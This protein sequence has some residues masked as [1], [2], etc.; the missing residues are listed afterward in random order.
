MNRGKPLGLGHET[1]PL[2]GQLVRD[3]KHGTCGILQAVTAECR[4]S[5][6]GEHTVRTAWLKSPPAATE[7][8]TPLEAIRPEPA[9]APA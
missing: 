8:D 1:H 3:T 7:W 4:Y 5:N 6:G 9:E 2:I